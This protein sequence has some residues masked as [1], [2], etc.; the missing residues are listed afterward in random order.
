VRSDLFPPSG[1]VPSASMYQKILVGTD[2]SQPAATA[3]DRAVI[4]TTT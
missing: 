4:V 1:R 3:V 2:G